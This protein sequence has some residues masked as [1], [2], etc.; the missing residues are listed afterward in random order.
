MMLPVRRLVLLLACVTFGMLATSV[1]GQSR[2]ETDLD[3]A[4]ALYRDGRFEEAIGALQSVIVAINE[5]RD[6][7]NRAVRLADAHFHLGLVYLAMRNEAAA[8]ENFRQ[9]VALDPNRTVDPEVYAP[10]VLTIFERARAEVTAAA[11]VARPEVSPPVTSPEPAGLRDM[12]VGGV[13][14]LPGTKLRLEREGLSGALVGRLLAL[15]ERAMTIGDRDWRIDLPR[16][17]VT[18]VQVATRQR[19][20]WLAGA[21][22]GVG[23]GA[24]LGATETPGCDSDGTCYTRAENIGYAAAG[25]GLIG[26]LIGALYKTDVW[27]DVPL[28]R[29][30]AAVRVERTRLT[31]AVVWRY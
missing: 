21:L 20:H 1:Y 9:V 26:A 22:I 25:A 2:V 5:Q 15:D 8:V 14:L 7:Q 3:G 19:D 24:A 27:S 18:R 10:R 29:P 31:M 6:L 28:G 13:R 12:V 23:A 11:A 16:D 4:K 17:R 30:A